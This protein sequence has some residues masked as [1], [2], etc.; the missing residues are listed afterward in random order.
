VEG[1]GS[2]I[3]RVEMQWANDNVTEEERRFD[4]RR[5]SSWK[6]YFWEHFLTPVFCQTNL[7]LL[8]LPAHYIF[9]SIMA[10]LPKRFIAYYMSHKLKMSNTAC[11][12]AYARFQDAKYMIDNNFFAIIHKYNLSAG[13][14]CQMT[15]DGQVRVS[16]SNE[17]ETSGM[18][19]MGSICG[20]SAEISQLKANNDVLLMQENGLEFGARLRNTIS[21]QIRKFLLTLFFLII[22]M[23]T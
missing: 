23:L 3:N 19:A 2:C 16:R 22:F 20:L 21:Q 9:V 18:A 11:D 7:A 13:I 12:R 8:G 1:V 5:A 15:V 10:R 6:T 4:R 17:I 14:K